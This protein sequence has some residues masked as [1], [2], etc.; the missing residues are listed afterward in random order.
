MF[1]DKNTLRRY[2]G[3]S[4]ENKRDT[5]SSGASVKANFFNIIKEIIHINA[6]N[7]Y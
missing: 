5:P 7:N 2:F 6:I 4:K 3:S 1:S